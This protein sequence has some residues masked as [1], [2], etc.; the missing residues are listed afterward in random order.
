M[1]GAVVM[2]LPL[3]AADL[4]GVEEIPVAARAAVVAPVRHGRHVAED[5]IERH[6]AL[7]W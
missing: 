5:G 7:S 1:P 4:A 6:R 3:D 2:E